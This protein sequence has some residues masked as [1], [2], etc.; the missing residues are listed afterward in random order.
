MTMNRVQ[1][2][3]RLSLHE[4]MKRF[5]TEGQY[6]AAL[7]ATARWPNGLSCPRCGQNIAFSI[8]AWA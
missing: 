6:A 3:Q 1:F 2:Q 8:V 7:E 5:G 4:F